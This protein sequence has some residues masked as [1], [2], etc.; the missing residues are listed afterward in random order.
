MAERGL[1]IGSGSVET[2][3]YQQYL[4]EVMARECEQRRKSKVQRLLKDSALPLEKSLQTS[5]S[6]GCRE[7]RRGSCERCWKAAFWIGKKTFWCSAILGSGKSHLLSAL[8]QDLVVV[9]ERK[10]YFTKCALLMQDLLDAFPLYFREKSG[11]FVPDNLR[12]AHHLDR[13][14]AGAGAVYA[15]DNPFCIPNEHSRSGCDGAGSHEEALPFGGGAV[16]Q[17]SL[18]SITP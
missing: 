14:T 18:T 2:L 5:I 8:A 12:D 15:F 13:L 3:S 9:G 16:R 4:L 1:G 17:P 7:K 6:N 11:F 10:M